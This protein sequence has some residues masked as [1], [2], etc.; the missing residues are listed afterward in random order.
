MS[1][2]VETKVPSIF[3]EEWRDQYTQISMTKSSSGAELYF[4]IKK[5]SGTKDR[6]KGASLII[7]NAVTENF[8]YMPVKLEVEDEKDNPGGTW[9]KQYS[10]NPEL[11]EE[12]LR[13]GR[14]LQ[15]IYKLKSESPD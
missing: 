12:R 2:S 10:Q 6:L 5:E 14:Q 15:E 11:W 8:G 4:G 1:E 9:K 3:P 13:S 7:E